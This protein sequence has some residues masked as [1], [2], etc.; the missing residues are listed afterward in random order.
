MPFVQIN[1]AQNL[2]DEVKKNISRSI[3]ESLVTGYILQGTAMLQVPVSSISTIIPMLS[4]WSSSLSICLM[5]S[6]SLS[7]C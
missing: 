3:H 2:T 6:K 7:K 5:E 1:L 4:P